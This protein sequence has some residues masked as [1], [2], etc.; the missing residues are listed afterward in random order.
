[1]KTETLS[2]GLAVLLNFRD[3]HLCHDCRGRA[4]GWPG[5]LHR[6]YRGSAVQSALR[7]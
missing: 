7:R 6:C 1:M 2:G 3:G 5:V 4:L